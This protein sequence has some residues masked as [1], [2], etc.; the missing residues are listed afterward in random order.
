[1]KKSLCVILTG[2]LVCMSV[3]ATSDITAKT[4]DG[5]IVIL[6]GDNTYEYFVK[7][8]PENEIGYTLQTD[9][10]LGVDWDSV[11]LVK[12]GN[13]IPSSSFSTCYTLGQ[14]YMLEFSLSGDSFPSTEKG[15]V[16]PVL[17]LSDGSEIKGF[18]QSFEQYY[19]ASN[20][21]KFKTGQ[22]K[23]TTTYSII[24][25]VPQG[26]TPAAV[27]LTLDQGDTTW[28]DVGTEAA[29]D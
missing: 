3:F 11:K 27:G 20:T 28:T 16:V 2:L 12:L 15:W 25:E 6:H 21:F 22:Q 1:M 9:K 4:E 18:G 5:R 24:F 13:N 14:F 19:T 17:K 8:N 29:L 7:E 23:R 10:F 26:T